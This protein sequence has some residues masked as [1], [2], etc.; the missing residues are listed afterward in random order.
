MY[1]MCVCACGITKIMRS[2]MIILGGLE[3]GTECR[4]K[5]RRRIR[6]VPCW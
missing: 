3:G 5:L 1:T 2:L 6:I 4:G